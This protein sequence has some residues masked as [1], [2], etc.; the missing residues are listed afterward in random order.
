VMLVDTCSAEK[1]GDIEACPACVPNPEC[2]APPGDPDPDPNDPG[3]PDAGDPTPSCTG[4]S[5]C[6]EAGGCPVGQFCSQD[7]CLVVIE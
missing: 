4:R 2:A 3:S 6:D 7:C 5:Q 1:I